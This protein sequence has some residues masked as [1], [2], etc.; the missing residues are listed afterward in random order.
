MS[1]AYIMVVTRRY[2]HELSA[3]TCPHEMLDFPIISW[4]IFEQTQFS[5]P[6]LLIVRQSTGTRDIAGH[7]L[8]V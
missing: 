5:L 3:P 4:T 1:N 7:S 6:S 8:S 2:W